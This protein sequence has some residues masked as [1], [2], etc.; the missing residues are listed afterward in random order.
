MKIH[1]I[2][3]VHIEQNNPNYSAPE[4]TDLVV[5]AGDIGEGISGLKWARTS[6]PDQQ[7][8][9]VCGNHEYYGHDLS[10]IDLMRETAS[11][12]DI[13]FLENNEVIINGVRF[14]GCT[15]W[16]NFNEFSLKD[17]EVSWKNMNDFGAIKAESWWNN[18]KNKCAAFAL[19]NPNFN[20]KSYYQ[21][22][23]SPIT[24]YLLHQK[25]ITWLTQKLSEK[26][27][28]TV[29]VTHHAPSFN[30]LKDEYYWADLQHS[31]CS[32]LSDFIAKN[33]INFWLH[34]HIHQRVDY[35]INNTRIMSNSMGY[36]GQETG[37]DAKL[38]IDV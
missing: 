10:I 32:D 15:L 26:H 11:K 12:L 3:D 30:Q 16:T 13:Y 20:K 24:S 34:G 18:E 31:Y 37:F 22:S 23:F 35:M 14:L 36:R 7:I 28:K 6:F 2:S 38:L 21:K 9:Y 5:L 8:I 19:M 1:L 4:A 25:S 17:I 33:N 29:V 27:E